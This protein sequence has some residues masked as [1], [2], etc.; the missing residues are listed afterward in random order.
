M[1][2]PGAAAGIRSSGG[3]LSLSLGNRSAL[4]PS[5]IPSS[6]SLPCLAQY[7]H[8]DLH[9]QLSSLKSI[10]GGESPPTDRT[11]FFLGPRLDDPNR[12][13]VGNK[14]SYE[15]GNLSESV[16]RTRDREAGPNVR[17]DRIRSEHR[18]DRPASPFSPLH[19]FPPPIPEESAPVPHSP[20]LRA[21]PA[22]LQSTSELFSSLPFVVLVLN[23]A[24]LWAI[25]TFTQAVAPAY[26][27]TYLNYEVSP[28]ISSSVLI[29]LVLQVGHAIIQL[30]MGFF[31]DVFFP[32]LVLRISFLLMAFAKLGFFFAFENGV[33]PYWA[34]ALG[35]IDGLGQGGMYAAYEIMVPEVVWADEAVSHVRRENLIYGYVDSVRE[36][37]MAI[38]FF[39]VGLVLEYVQPRLAERIAVGLV[40]LPFIAI[41][42]LI[43]CFFPKVMLRGT[44]EVE[45]ADI[46]PADK[47][48]RQAWEK[49]LHGRTR[50]GELTEP[51]LSVPINRSDQTLEASGRPSDYSKLSPPGGL[52][53]LCGDPA[54]PRVTGDENNGVG[55]GEGRPQGV[56][57]GGGT[58]PGGRGQGAEAQRSG[59]GNLYACRK[60]GFTSASPMSRASG[61]DSHLVHEVE[62]PQESVK[63]A[64]AGPHPRV[65]YEEGTKGAGPGEVAPWS[66]LIG[67]GAEVEGIA[68]SESSGRGKGDEG[69]PFPMEP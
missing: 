15:N 14:G 69:L 12:V 67:R 22:W 49:F 48:W 57:G 37:S 52:L 43:H 25:M 8:K 20:P 23:H 42:A 60:K 5:S 39:G 29:V 21:L 36:L 45:H 62:A 38:S 4:P 59:A 28:Y 50:T 1:T 53:F 18:T 63:S 51:L 26:L 46:G 56:S 33:P 16:H 7:H 61:S 47:P 65:H 34:F 54:L 41:C 32:E 3:T 13:R 30:L 55:G 31:P 10:G 58:L 44:P 17:D 6:S 24:L 9:E 11:D 2:G 64:K 68:R 35:L 66:G 27:H 40:P 19:H